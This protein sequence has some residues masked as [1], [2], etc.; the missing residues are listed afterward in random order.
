MFSMLLTKTTKS[1]IQTTSSLNTKHSIVLSQ[2][3]FATK[4]AGGS[5]KN[6]R[7]S[8]PK[9]LGVKKFGN[10]KVTAGAILIRQRGKK[11]RCCPNGTTFMA[12][13]H[14]IH[15]KSDGWVRFEK[16]DRKRQVVSILEAPLVNEA[17]HAY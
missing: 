5:T 4:K 10:E 3:R 9:M 15:A 8:K 11:Y 12:K 7:D 17:G 2:I 13:D 6:G 1:I 16:D 14:T